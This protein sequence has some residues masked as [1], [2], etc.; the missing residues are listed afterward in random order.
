M[1]GEYFEH[2]D[3]KTYE[4]GFLI[5]QFA[6]KSISTQNV[7]PTFDEL[8]MFRQSNEGDGDI[9][10]LFASR[11]KGHFMKGDAVIVVSGD[12]KN[13]KGWVEKVEGACAHIR[14]NAEGLPVFTYLLT[15]FSLPVN[16]Y[17]LFKSLRVCCNVSA[18]NSFSK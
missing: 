15:Y 8:E 2:I 11:K 10:T 14:P 9:S 17:S 5:R 12:L 1:T 6:M 4:D 13:L 18:E 3:G 16:I 7:Q